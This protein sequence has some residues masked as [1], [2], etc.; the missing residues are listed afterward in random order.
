MFLPQGPTFVINNKI[1]L[2]N[3]L[4]INKKPSHYFTIEVLYLIKS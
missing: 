1:N 3:N 2:E 4:Y